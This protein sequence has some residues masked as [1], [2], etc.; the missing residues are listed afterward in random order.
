VAPPDEDDQELPPDVTP[1]PP[2][3]PVAPPEDV[4]AP[5]NDGED[6]EG[7]DGEAHGGRRRQKYVV[8]DV[9]VYVL[10]ERVQYYGNDGKLVTESL[11]DYA[12]RT[13][14]ERFASLDAFLKTWNEAD[15]KKVIVDELAEHGVF[16]DA[17]ADEVGKDLSAFD[18]VCHL[19]F[20]Q[21]AL[22]RRERANNVRKR[23][24]FTK[25]GEHARSVL[26]ALLTKFADEGVDDIEDI[27]LL[28][29]RPLTEKGT[30][31]Q[32]IQTFGGKEPYLQA[33]RE[34]EDELYRA[35]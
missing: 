9:P 1:V 26:D 10:A 11:R 16:F 20:D 28:R 3:E 13:I 35:S 27:G 2:V 5:G 14:R 31:V 30:P 6:A 7:D 25:Y 33:V 4:R 15:R 24:Y 22:T 23:N 19:A 21:P 18:L 8:G 12:R 32:I 34:L 29:V 17:L